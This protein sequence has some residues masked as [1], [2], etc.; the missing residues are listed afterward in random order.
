MVQRIAVASKPVFAVI[1]GPMVPP[2]PLSALHHF[3][4]FC[5]DGMP[6][7]IRLHT[8]IRLDPEVYLF[9]RGS[10]F[11]QPR[12]RLCS[13]VCVLL[14]RLRLPPL[15]QLS[16]PL[17]VRHLHAQ[18]RGSSLPQHAMHHVGSNRRSQAA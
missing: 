13:H 7:T 9:D 1:R 8:M 2:T 5:A 3:R 4:P 10:L 18:V 11:C 15:L 12:R 16:P 6:L 14:S 17:A